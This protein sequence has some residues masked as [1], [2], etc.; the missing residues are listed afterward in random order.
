MRWVEMPDEPAAA[1][2]SAAEPTTATETVAQRGAA[3]VAREE[4][5][6][7]ASSQRATLEQHELPRSLRRARTLPNQVT[8][9][10]TSYL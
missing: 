4:G 1:A 6:S 9:Y 10:Y 5:R 8:F 2:S 3:R 7:A